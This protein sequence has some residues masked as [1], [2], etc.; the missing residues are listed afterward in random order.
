M[1]PN[2]RVTVRIDEEQS[3]D[4]RGTSPLGIDTDVM[5]FM[6]RDHLFDSRMFN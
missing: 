3:E 4:Q 1:A 6:M 5:I 2:T